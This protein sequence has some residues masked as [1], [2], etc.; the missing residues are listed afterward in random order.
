M[1]LVVSATVPD[2][3]VMAADSRTTM[4]DVSGQ[5]RITTDYTQK[6]FQFGPCVIGTTGY[7]AFS[8]RN[9]ASH[10]EQVLQIRK[11]ATLLESV[12]ALEDEF[13]RIWCEHKKWLTD[14]NIPIPLRPGGIAIQ[15]LIAGYNDEG[16]TQ[17]AQVTVYE[18]NQV[19]TAG[20]FNGLI[21]PAGHCF[22]A[23]VGA[24]G[25]VRRVVNGYDAP[26][27]GDL[28]DDISKKLVASA[29]Y[30][31][32]PA[33]TLQDAR[34]FAMLQLEYTIAMQRFT[35]A[36]TKENAEFTNVGGFIELAEVTTTG[37]EWKRRKELTVATQ[38]SAPGTAS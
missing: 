9:V 7:N 13:F 24:A 35:I 3:I 4:Q 18:P 36:S 8:G 33:L 19:D 26:A 16:K 15:F 25:I 17:S 2:G 30:I 28:P 11:P 12:A 5:W 23:F 14:Q 32:F 22:C 21:N 38:L 34:D 10:I 1:T 6:L 27:V 20:H 29:G 31:P 37:F